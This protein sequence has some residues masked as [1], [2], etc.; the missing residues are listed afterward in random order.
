MKNI[1]YKHTILLIVAVFFISINAMG[2]VGIGT[3]TPETSSMLEVKST[4]KGMLIPRMTTAQRIA[5]SSPATGLLVFD[6]TTETF[7]FYTTAWEELVAGSSG[8]NELV[9]AD[10][11]T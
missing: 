7:W 1:N 8:G 10:G 6:L 2:Q 5:I 11:D 4:T 9:D 3:T